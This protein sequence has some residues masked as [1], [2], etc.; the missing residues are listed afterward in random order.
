[1]DGMTRIDYARR[2]AVDID[3]FM[4]DYDYYGYVDAF[5]DREQAVV[6]LT[7]DLISGQHVDGI[8]YY[9]KE[10]VSEHEVEWEFGAQVLIHRIH[11]LYR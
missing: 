3:T 9:L 1:M 2:L 8:I 5:D 7:R 10:I 6:D 4:Y 11:A